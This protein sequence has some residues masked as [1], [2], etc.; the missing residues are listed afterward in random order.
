MLDTITQIHKRSGCRLLGLLSGDSLLVPLVLF[1]LFPLKVGDTFDVSAYLSKLSPLYAKAAMERAGLM[2]TRRDH[3][4]QEVRLSLQQQGYPDAVIEAT[5][6]RLM[7]LSYLD[8]ERFARG[9]LQNRSRKKGLRSLKTELKRKGI[10]DELADKLLAEIN[11]DHQMESAI[12]IAKKALFS[13]EPERYK[14]KQRAYA[15]LAR[16]GYEGD[17]IKQAISQAL[18]EADGE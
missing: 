9:F 13:S 15:A 8:D 1:K 10:S 7:Q 17:T 12:K 18:F 16:R 14:R 3:S 4:S 5:L 6:Q 2:L 11:P